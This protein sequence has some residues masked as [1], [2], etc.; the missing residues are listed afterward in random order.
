MSPNTCPGPEA[1]VTLREITAETVRPICGLQVAEHQKHVVAPNA[2]SI[3]EAYFQR[4]KAWLRAVYAGQVPVGFVMLYDN[5]D[6]AEYFL[7]RF[8]IDARYQGRG[9][10]RRALQC[11]V[12]YVRTRP[13]AK[14]ISVSFHK[15]DGG[16]EGFYR[17]IGFVET[18]EMNGDEHLAKLTL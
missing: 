7:W 9:F 2:L 13:G 6:Q 1:E 17:R 8:M 16:P 3:A 5:P 10:G 12:E 4:E 11:L 15:G 14:E 18:G